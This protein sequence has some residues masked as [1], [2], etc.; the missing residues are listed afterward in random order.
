MF[1]T[2]WGWFHCIR[3][4]WAKLGLD[5]GAC[6]F[7]ALEGK[8]WRYDGLIGMNAVSMILRS[9]DMVHY[10]TVLDCHPVLD[11]LYAAYM[12]LQRYEYLDKRFMDTK[13]KSPQTNMFVI[14]KSY[15]DGHEHYKGMDLP[16]Y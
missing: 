9:F 12:G 11:F 8:S 4:N 7:R 2:E 10:F 13:W 3:G 14:D 1:Q 15:T 5:S 16:N 6:L